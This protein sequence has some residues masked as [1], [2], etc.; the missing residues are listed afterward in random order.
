MDGTIVGGPNRPGYGGRGAFIF[1]VGIEPELAVLDQLLRPDDVLIDVGAN[2]GV[3]TLRGARVVGPKGV[4]VALEPNPE[5]LAILIS[6]IRRNGYTNVRVR[7]LGASDSCGEFPFYENHGKPN[8]FSLV[9]RDDCP[10]M[11]S[12]LTVD[13]DSLIAWEA[14]DRIDMIKIDAEGVEDRVLAGAGRT[15][16]EH[17]PA[18]IAEAIHE[19]L[20]SVPPG[21]RGFVAPGSPNQLLLPEGHHLRAVV[22]QLGW[23]AA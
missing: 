3:Y 20:T 10:D 16:R 14:L 12:I 7:G 19:G 15:I 17:R 8:S 18:I 2:S 21:Y 22:R 4:V 23:S 13:L 5:M 11:F 1:G 9:Q 6:N